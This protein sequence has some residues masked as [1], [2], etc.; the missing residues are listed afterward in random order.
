MVYD[1]DEESEDT[2]TVTVTESEATTNGLIAVAYDP[3]ILTYKGSNSDLAYSSIADTADGTKGVITFAYANKTALAADTALVTLTFS[4]PTEATEI[5]LDTLERGS[6]VE[7]DE[8]ETITLTASEQ[9]PEVK[10]YGC[11]LSLEGDIAINYYLVLPDEIFD[12]P[13]AYV[14]LNDSKLLIADAPSVEQNGI[15]MYEFKY[16]VAAK[17]MGKDV[18]LHAYSGAD[19]LLPLLRYSTG[20]D[21]TETGYHYTV[22]RYIQLAIKSGGNANL[23]ELMKAMSDYGSKAQ[24]HFNYEVDNAAEIYY[25]EA[26]ANVQ[27]IY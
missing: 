10:A 8:I 21:L 22:Q 24:V 16:R 25:P 9:L 15:T 17:E 23:I 7:L 11:S 2:V 27:S 26:I 20:K 12:D 4:K 13:E 6:E 5:E 14:T 1:L 19:Q 3:T 18:V